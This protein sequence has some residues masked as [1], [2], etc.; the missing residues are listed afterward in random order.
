MLRVLHQFNSVFLV[1]TNH[2]KEIGD[3]AIDVVFILAKLM[4][5][6][7]KPGVVPLVP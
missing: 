3:A 5:V 6:G 4:D 1:G 7:S 2:C